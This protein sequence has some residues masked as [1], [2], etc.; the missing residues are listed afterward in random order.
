MIN[1]LFE[2]FIN[3]NDINK[4]NIK[5]YLNTFLNPIKYYLILL[6]FILL[7]FIY[8]IIKIENKIQIII[9]NLILL[10]KIDN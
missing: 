8:Y 9:N 3:N 2:S 5:N 4:N 10:K 6:I 1:S 7:S